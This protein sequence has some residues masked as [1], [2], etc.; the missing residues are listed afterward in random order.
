MI[1]CGIA[2]CTLRERLEKAIAAGHAVE[3]K[4]IH[5]KEVKR[6]QEQ[7]ISVNVMLVLDVLDAHLEPNHGSLDCEQW[8]PVSYASR[9]FVSYERNYAQIEKEVLSLSL[10]LNA[11]RNTYSSSSTIINH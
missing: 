7:L 1:V 10:P 9:A 8:F 3:E 4:K 11:F 6:H 2:D 5:A